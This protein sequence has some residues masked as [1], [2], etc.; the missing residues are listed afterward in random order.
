M[1][2]DANRRVSRF[3]LDSTWDDPAHPEG[4]YFRSDHLPYARAG[5]PAIFFTTLLHPDYHTPDDEP[6]R[7]D[8][9]KLTRMTQW[10]YATGW[11]V[12]NAAQRPA[13]DPGFRLER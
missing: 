10:M 2:L 11:S 8:I 13:V 4:W 1:A 6:E 9:A 12:A 7:I 3:A 5:V